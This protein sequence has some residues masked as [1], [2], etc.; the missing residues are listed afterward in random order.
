[1][2]RR[3]RKV[4]LPAM[5]SQRFG[6][7]GADFRPLPLLGNTHVQTV[8]GAFW[9]T[10]VWTGPL[11][12]HRIV[13]PDGDQVV[14][15]DSRPGGWHEGAPIV[16]LVHGLGGSHQS[17][18]MH[19]MAMR[20]LPLGVRVIRMDLRGCGRGF[21]L[22]RRTY[23]AGS[24]SDVRAVVEVLHRAHPRSP[25]S[26]VGFSLGG[27]VV[28]KLAGEASER[29]VPGLARVAAVA[30]P[31]NLERCS[32]LISLPANRIYE[33][34]FIR[35]LLALVQKRKRYFPE[36]SALRF[37][38]PLTLR[39]FDDL[40]TAPQAGFANALDYYRRS[41]SLS[42]IPQI[43]QPTL[44]MT[45]RDDPFVAVESF[46]SLSVPKHI[47][48]QISP[49]GGHLGFLGWDGAGGIRWAERRLADWL[50]Q[51]V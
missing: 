28:L 9:P 7:A 51:P 13:L 24:S 4:R 6:G 8:L 11:R 49:R 23:N 38:R 42:L 35:D 16:V 33:L 47:E 10:P 32:E 43:Q 31:I 44:I 18:Y 46:E 15:H 40:Y 37:P 45:A 14:I 12:E 5:A 22:A 29:P 25:L 17:G 3:L 41:A 19:R 50:T 30:P 20:L 27:N 1:M 36:L 21:A 34:H 48:V 26:L 2:F 39:Q